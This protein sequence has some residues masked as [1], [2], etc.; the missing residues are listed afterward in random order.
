MF[1]RNILSYE[2]DG[3]AGQCP[4]CKSE[5]IVNTINTPGRKSVDI[6]CVKC[7]KAELYSGVF[8]QNNER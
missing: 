6:S 7:K 5:L 3:K 8:K 2:K 4:I 1:E